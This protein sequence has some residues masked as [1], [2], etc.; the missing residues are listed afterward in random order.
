MLPHIFCCKKVCRFPPGILATLPK[1]SF[2]PPDSGLVTSIPSILLYIPVRVCYYNMVKRVRG[3]FHG[4][5]VIFIQ[6]SF[7]GIRKERVFPWVCWRT[8]GTSSAR[9]PLHATCWRSFCCIRA[10]TFWCITALRTGYT[11]T[12]GSFWPGGSA[13]MAAAAPASRSTPVPPSADACS[14]I[15]AWASC[16]VRPVRSGTTAPSTTVS[17]W[18]APARTPASATPLWATTC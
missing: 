10:F 7:I 6:S 15:T 2:S 5:G 13:S 1:S 11:S 3:C 12:S 18:A 8:R 4:R 9:T 14:L 17:L 16:S